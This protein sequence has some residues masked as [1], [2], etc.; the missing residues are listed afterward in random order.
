MLRCRANNYKKLPFGTLGI[1]SITGLFTSLQFVF[2]QILGALER[3]PTAL[4]NCE[5]W[6]VI[7]PLLVHSDGWQQIA[8]NFAAILVV[9][10][11]V[12]SIFGIDRLLVLYLICGFVGEVAG[13]AWQPSGAGAS[14]AGAGLL[15]ALAFWLLLRSVP[16]KI[17][18]A[19][20]LIGAV[21]L[22]LR[23]DIHGPP[24]LAGALTAWV[25]SRQ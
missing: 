17:G 23:K 15:G 6:R 13:F 12:E 25:M 19:V 22:C 20:V 24:L 7:T 16:G 14:V 5:W 8:F 4:V 9:G 3:T 21:I 18:G 2:P 10:T 11:S 1:L